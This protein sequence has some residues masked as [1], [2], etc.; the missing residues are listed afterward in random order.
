MIIELTRCDYSTE[1]DLVSLE[2]AL[3]C[4][5]FMMRGYRRLVLEELTFT[6][7]ERKQKKVLD[8]IKTAEGSPVPW[9]DII[10]ATR[11][12][13]RDL[14]EVVQSLEA[15]DKIELVKGKRG[16]RSYSYKDPKAPIKIDREPR[17]E[18]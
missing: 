18:L 17:R 5:E 9:R 2:T 8:I 15:Q 16:G 14:T 13:V 12:K 1:I 4:A 3:D 11:Y 10:T 6:V 7:D